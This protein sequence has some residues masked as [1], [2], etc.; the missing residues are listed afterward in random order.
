[1]VEKIIMKKLEKIFV[2]IILLSSALAMGI[3]MLLNSDNQNKNIVITVDNNVVEKISLNNANEGDLYAFNFNTDIGSIE[4]RN[5]RVRM[6]EMSKEICPKSIC[7]ET[8]WIDKSYQSIVC[9][10][11]KIVV[12]IEVDNQDDEVDMVAMGSGEGK[13][14]I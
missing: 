5:G 10:P 4:T 7:S 12:T 14:L 2:A 9:L 11:N 3:M 1:M 13:F 6:L 8:G